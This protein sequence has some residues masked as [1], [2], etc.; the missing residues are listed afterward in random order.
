MFHRIIYLVS[1]VLITLLISGSA[2]VNVSTK[3]LA[4]TDEKKMDEVFDVSSGQKLTVDLKIGGDIDISGW[5]KEQVSVKV[6]IKG[7]DSEEIDVDISQSAS[8]IDINAEYVGDRDN[9]D[10][11]ANFTIMVPSRFDVEFSTMGG[12]TKLKTLTGDLEGTTMGGD[13]LLTGLQGNIE[14]TTMGGDIDLTESDV[15]GFV[16]TMGGDVSI[17]N[18][19]GSVSAKSMGGDIIQ[20][21]V[22]RRDGDSIGE[23][24]NVTTMGGDLIIDEAADGAKLKTMGGDIIA[25]S[26]GKFL[27]AST[28]GGDIQ[29]KEVDGWIKATTMGGEVDIKMVGNPDEGDRSV[30]LKSMGGDITLS[31]P[32]GLSMELDLDITYDRKHED[33]VK[34]VSDFQFDE[35]H[36]EEWND[37][38]TP[39]KHL[40]GTGTV[41]GGK[42]KIKIKTINSKIY[43][44]KN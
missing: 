35:K 27:D 43:L 2:P 11:N 34:I 32:E 20:K 14:M 23:E 41:N 22:K 5:E 37:D 38:D 33:D 15:D 12:D 26:V 42:N 40:Y 24:V 1:F 18:V 9:Y 3:Y 31:V 29:A 4:D 7:D 10:A 44:N 8:G 16:K 28:M 17:E 21:N 13:I 19:T 39:K 30:F 36:S 25:N 6:K